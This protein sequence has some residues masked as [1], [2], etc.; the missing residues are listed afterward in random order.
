MPEID[1][2]KPKWQAPANVVAYTSCRTGGDSLPPFASFNVAQHVGDDAKTVELNRQKLSNHKNFVWLQQVHSNLCLTLPLQA[3]LQ[4]NASLAVDAVC[5]REPMQVCAVMTADCLP[6]LLC[7]KQGTQV[8]AVHAGWRGLADGIIE[9]TVKQMNDAG[10]ELLAWLGPAISQANFEV[11]SEVYQAF[12]AYPEAFISSPN[13]TLDQPK[14]LAD[15][16]AIAR[17]KLTALGISNITGGDFC[18][19]AQDSLF[20]SHRRATHL[21]LNTTGRMVSAVYLR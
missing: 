14:Y 17:R 15:L 5:T 10:S 7:N 13:S 19:Y 18:T 8:A 9:N 21:G 12:S 1:L 20:F 6:I 11:G 16:Y 3:S 4:N 2:I